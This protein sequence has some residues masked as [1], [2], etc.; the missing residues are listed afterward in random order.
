MISPAYLV[1]GDLEQRFIQGACPGQPVQKIG[2]NGKSVSIPAIAKRL[3]TQG[4]L[5]QRRYQPLVVVF[6]REGRSQTCTEIEAEL[7]DLLQFEDI[8]VELIIGI[9]DREIENW[10][11]A[12][13]DV[14]ARCSRCDTE[15]PAHNFEGTHGKHKLKHFLPKGETY[16][17][18]IQGCAWLKKCRP[19]E[20]AKRSPSFAAFLARLQHLECWW[21]EHEELV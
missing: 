5:L 11:L 1:E 14:F 13:W 20:I 21:L 4:R 10:I 17:E 8:N 9:A 15:Q 2:L 6:D 18:T 3:G 16:T 19:K 7:R 12:D